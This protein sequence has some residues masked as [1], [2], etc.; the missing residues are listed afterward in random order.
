MKQQGNYWKSEF[1]KV[2]EQGKRIIYF[3]TKLFM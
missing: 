2:L 1:V 3:V